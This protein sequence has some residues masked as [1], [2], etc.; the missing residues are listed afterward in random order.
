[1]INFISI[2][3]LINISICY[4]ESFISEKKSRVAASIQR[5]RDVKL[6]DHNDGLGP[7]KL[8]NQ[9]CLLKSANDDCKIFSLE[10]NVTNCEQ[11]RY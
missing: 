8:L 6:C 11:M 2:V 7:S 3:I 10:K 4:S 1:M 5:H 9:R